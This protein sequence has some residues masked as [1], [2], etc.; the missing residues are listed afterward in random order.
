MAQSSVARVQQSEKQERQ[1]EQKPFLVAEKKPDRVAAVV[2]ML[3]AHGE[4]PA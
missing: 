2:D 1:P 3:L 4:L